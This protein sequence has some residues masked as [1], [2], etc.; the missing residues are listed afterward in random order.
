M[1]DEGTTAIERNGHVVVITLQRDGAM[2]ARSVALRKSLIAAIDEAESDPDVRAIVLTGSGRA[3]SVGLDLVEAAARGDLSI[4]DA[5][6]ARQEANDVAR[7]AAATKPTIAAINGYA[8]GGGLELALACDIRIAAA[9]ARIGL[10][11]VTR[12][13]LPG[14]GGTQRLPRLIGVP[15]A[16]EVILTGEL[17]TAEDAARLGIVSRVVPAAELVSDAVAIA[18]RISEN[19]PVAVR[20]AKQAVRATMETSLQEGLVLESALSVLMLSS[21]DRREGIA[22]FREKRT[23]SWKGR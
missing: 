17:F 2:N 11:E 16:M 13:T 1:T 4:G 10:P 20:F 8:L 9:D 21:E 6:D 18:T 19:A 12:G 23:P 7:V 15:A 5:L 3:F 14:N 22:A